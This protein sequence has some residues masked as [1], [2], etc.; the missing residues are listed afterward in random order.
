MR[1]FVTLSCTLVM[2]WALVAEL[3]HVL[4]ELRVYL[5]VGGLYV[6]FAALT[7]PFRSG[8]AASCIGGMI[9]DANAPV[10][11]GL[12]LMLFA[13][14]HATVYHLSDRVPRDDNIAAVIVTLLTNLALFLVFSIS[15]IHGSAPSATLGPRLLMD[16]VCS[17][18]FLALVTP[19]FF[20]LQ[21]RSLDVGQVVT[22]LYERRFGANRS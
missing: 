18:V 20:A 12:H 11:F 8:L 17:Q 1:R 3:N 13:A 14:A 16:L 2:L 21:A 9:C 7:Q 10:S 6:T 19:W 5:F 22:D 15:Q 4:T